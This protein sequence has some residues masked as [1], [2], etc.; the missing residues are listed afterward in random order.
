VLL[1]IAEA[2]R[3]RSAVLR[4]VGALE[5][6][7]ADVTTARGAIERVRA[8]ETDEATARRADVELA[9]LLFDTARQASEDGRDSVQA[10]QLL[11]Q[12]ADL[13]RAGTRTMPQTVLLA[14]VLRQHCEVQRTMHQAPLGRPSL[15]AA[16]R[17]LTTV[18]VADAHD[19]MVR[20]ARAQVEAELGALHRDLGDLGAAET[21]LR[22]A[23][24]LRE[25][26]ARDYPRNQGHRHGL[27]VCLTELCAVLG[28]RGSAEW[29]PVAERAEQLAQALYEEAKDNVLFATR[30]CVTSNQ[31]CR[32]RADMRSD[33][34]SVEDVHA[35]FERCIAL[36]RQIAT[37]FPDIP[38][39]RSHVGAIANNYARFCG[40]Q[41]RWQEAQRL[42]VEA[43]EHQDAA[44]AGDPSVWQYQR[45]RSN[46]YMLLTQIE[47]EL[48]RLPE[49][50]AAARSF[51]AQSTADATYTAF[52]A[53]LFTR[54]ASA[55]RAGTA[56]DRDVRADELEASALT[57]S[58]HT[59]PVVHGHA[60][61]VPERDD[62]RS[63]VTFHQGHQTG[64]CRM[65][66][67]DRRI[68]A[69]DMHPAERVVTLLST[70]R[71]CQTPSRPPLRQGRRST[72]PASRSLSRARSTRP[73]SMPRLSAI[74]PRLK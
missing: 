40:G 29:R 65:T 4:A 68:S 67:S 38:R 60:A 54:I 9:A 13:L 70:G 8:R 11:S 34:E 28:A 10:G 46:H 6:A 31:R 30:L 2:H 7:T 49:A 47:I 37:R 26:L 42:V 24:T 50:A 5:A 22:G 62:G 33:A 63:A 16:Q 14:D 41:N 43:I 48:G 3:H 64:G 51:V 71:I 39:V 15:E 21:A 25:E 72:S 35:A 12:A 55:W 44:V 61:A 45:F 18:D 27:E 23:V 53:K 20:I 52:G 66:P 36:H 17:E 32:M 73:T 1:A 74:R 57:V 69:T 56:A 19:P 59:R 58:G